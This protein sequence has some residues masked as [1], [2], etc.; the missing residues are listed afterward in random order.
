MAKITINEKEYLD[1]FS[2]YG[3]DKVQEAI[4]KK[5]ESESDSS[6][7]DIINES[8]NKKKFDMYQYM[9]KLL[10]SK[11]V[12]EKCKDKLLHELLSFSKMKYIKDDILYYNGYLE[13]YHVGRE[14]YIC[15]STNKRKILRIPFLN[16]KGKRL[17]IV[18]IIT[19]E[20]GKSMTLQIGRKN[21]INF[22]IF[23][24]T[25]GI[26]KSDNI[27]PIIGQ[28]AE[29]LS[30]KNIFYIEDTIIKNAIE[31]YMVMNQL[32]SKYNY[33]EVSKCVKNNIC[34]Y[35]DKVSTEYGIIRLKSEPTDKDH[36]NTIRIKMS[37]WKINSIINDRIIDIK[38]ISY[39]DD[40][41]ITDKMKHYMS[42]FTC[43]LYSNI[44]I[45]KDIE[46]KKDLDLTNI[47]DLLRKNSDFDNIQF[48]S[49]KMF[50]LHGDETCIKHNIRLKISMF[51]KIFTHEYDKISEC[52]STE[53]S[54][55]YIYGLVKS[56]YSIRESGFRILG[57]TI[58]D[59]GSTLYIYCIA[60]DFKD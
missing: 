28:I 10:Y 2:K 26:S 9:E 34:D 45:F 56:R 20:D 49:T 3:E 51:I 24:A 54:H 19:D 44:E 30:D 57:F 22:N 15:D 23:I 29:S 16:I 41:C 25:S 14:F 31:D 21:K 5:L 48:S 27:S 35:I 32:H 50:S 60:N 6:I 55:K 17:S 36:K 7:Y 59:D 38:N 58:I 43:S 18:K 52:L 37:S 53:E 11:S 42:E 12:L 39:I 47:R 1:A 40:K 4:I 8:T 13:L 46:F 33:E